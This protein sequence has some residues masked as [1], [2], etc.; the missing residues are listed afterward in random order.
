VLN[1][2]LASPEHLQRAKAAA[3][4]AAQMTFSWERQEGALLDAVARALAYA[5]RDQQMPDDAAGRDRAA[6]SLG[7]R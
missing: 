1:S 7:I 5:R 3:L 6:R 2:L 4:E